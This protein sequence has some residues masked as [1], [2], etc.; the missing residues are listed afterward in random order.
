MPYKRNSKADV[1]LPRTSASFCSKFY[2]YNYNDAENW[3]VMASTH[4]CERL[5]ENLSKLIELK[6]KVI[7]ICV[8]Q[9]FLISNI[10]KPFEYKLK[11][12]ICKN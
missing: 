3:L 12:T 4:Y 1:T 7:L 6:Y 2:I 11:G 10:M 5:L 9:K 8:R